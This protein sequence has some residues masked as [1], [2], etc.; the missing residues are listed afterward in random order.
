M[1]AARSAGQRGA[2]RL[3]PLA[4]REA[5]RELLVVPRRPHRHRDR[6]AADRI[7][8]AG[9]L[10]ADLERL[11]DRDQVVLRAPAGSRATRTAAVAP[12]TR[13]PTSGLLVMRANLARA[14]C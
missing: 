2:E 5:E 4:D 11:L 1:F 8:S 3:E 10:D 6:L 14:A 13:S 9:S 12:G 7:S